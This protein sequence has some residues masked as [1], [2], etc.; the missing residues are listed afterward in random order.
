MR[1]NIMI[2][3]TLM[4]DVLR[5]TGVKTKREAVELGLKTLLMLKQQEAIKAFKG[6]LTW[7]GD[8]E[9]MRTDG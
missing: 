3:E 1:T 4:A 5:A 9:Q 2:D 8:L 6:R 7:E